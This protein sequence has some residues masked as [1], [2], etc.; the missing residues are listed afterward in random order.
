MT[1]EKRTLE[2]C[3]F[4][5]INSKLYV[6]RKCQHDTFTRGKRY[7]EESSSCW[8]DPVWH[9][10]T[11]G[12]NQR[13]WVIVE[14]GN[15]SW[16]FWVALFLGQSSE[17]WER[18]FAYDGNETCLLTGYL[19]LILLWG[20][21]KGRTRLWYTPVSLTLKKGSLCLRMSST[22]RRERA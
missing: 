13:G 18:K 12:W 8:H 10:R 7:L 4:R 21:G 20:G 1:W 14:L 6:L 9:Q 15:R 16:V 2:G 3:L 5:I 22:V 19:E 11:A 17:K